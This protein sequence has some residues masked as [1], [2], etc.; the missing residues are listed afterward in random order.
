MMDVGG[1]TQNGDS[2]PLID[3]SQFDLPLIA[4]NDQ[5]LADHEKVLVDIDKSSKGKTV[6]RTAAI[7]A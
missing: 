2:A 4:A 5:E 6:W 7:P 3:L 1:G